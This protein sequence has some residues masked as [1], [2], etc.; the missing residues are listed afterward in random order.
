M[1]PRILIAHTRYQQ[2][3]GEDQVVEAE[4]QLLSQHDHDIA[5]F[6]EDNHTIAEMPRLRLAMNTIW[7]RA[8]SSKAEVLFRKFRPD[9]LHVH[10]TFPLMSPSIYWAAARHSIPVVQTL[11]NYRLVCPQAMLLRNGKVC[12]DCLTR[13]PLPAIRHKCYRDS[14]TQTA[15]ISSM[16]SIHRSIGTFKNK[17]SAYIALTNFS[18]SK[19]IESGLPSER[20]FVKPNF[21]DI[22]Q[23][24]RA[25]G[26]RGLYVGRLSEEKGLNNLR[27]ALDILS[28]TDI[29]AI[30]SG[31][32]ETELKSSVHLHLH[33]WKSSDDVHTAMRKASFLVIPSIWYEGLPVTVIEAFACGLPVIASN[34]GSLGELIEDGLTGLLFKP[35]SS[36]HLAEK[37]SWA[38]THLQ[39]LTEMGKLARLNYE[40][41]FSPDSNYRRLAE[42]YQHASNDYSD[43]PNPARY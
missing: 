19:F 21:V 28:N 27:E 9:I 12:E 16:I 40:K 13:L 42:I 18:K 41:H 6:T 24:A 25:T 11:H 37:I 5:L 39:E 23:L 3:G 20:I 14:A 30:G 1:K 29:D 31:P 32:L 33:G 26:S 8:T 35:G 4:A 38:N 7:S 34:I 43:A 22:P 36:R 2:R 10:N 17:V 15:V